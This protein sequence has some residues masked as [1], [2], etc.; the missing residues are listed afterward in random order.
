[1]NA[2]KLPSCIITSRE[3]SNS[4]L[5]VDL[6][7]GTNVL[8]ARGAA[9]GEHRPPAMRFSGSGYSGITSS[10]PARIWFASVSLSRLA[11]KIL[12]Y[13]FALP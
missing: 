6:E 13:A 5:Y 11:S 7:Q 8:T 3:K 12:L 10:W 9:G 2:E 1:M 4:A